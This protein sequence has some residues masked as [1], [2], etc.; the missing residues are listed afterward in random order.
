SDNRSADRK[1]S[2]DRRGT[3]PALRVEVRNLGRAV[4]GVVSIVLGAGCGGA[5]QDRGDGTAGH[6]GSGIAGTVGTG[7]VGGVGGVAGG[8]NPGDGGDS[9]VQT[10]CGG[11]GGGT[12]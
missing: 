2:G 1:T 10:R 8:S 5:I 7:G 12:L 4:S 9:F 3:K 11:S 6:G